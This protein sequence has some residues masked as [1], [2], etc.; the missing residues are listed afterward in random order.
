MRMFSGLADR[1][2]AMFVPARAAG[3]SCIPDE[4]TQT[5]TRACAGGG[6]QTCTRLVI[7]TGRCTTTYS[8]WE[9]GPCS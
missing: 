6:T 9:C 1:A 5:E 4:F 2:L 7:L 8:P 3:A